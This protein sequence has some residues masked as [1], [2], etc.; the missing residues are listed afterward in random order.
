MSAAHE[1][2]ALSTTNSDEGLSFNPCL[3]NLR[4]VKWRIN[5]GILPSASS[6]IEDLR[7]AAANSRR[8]YA[9][10]RKDLLV[11]PYVAKTRSEADNLAVDNPLSQNPDST[12]GRFFRN[13]ELEKMLD[14]DLSRLYPEHGSYFQTPACQA[15]LRRI[16]LL[17]CLKYQQTHYRQGMHELLAPLL[18]VLHVDVQH[19]V[20]LRKLHRNHFNDRFDCVSF[21]EN[22]LGVDKKFLHGSSYLLTNRALQNGASDGLS[23]SSEKVSSLDEIDPDVRTV[24]LACDAYGAEGELGILLSERFMEHDAYCM[25]DALMTG[26]GG[27]V[28]MADFFSTS[29][30]IGSLM[31]LPP[32]LEA[33]LSLYHLLSFVD[34]SLYFHLVDLGVEP[35]Y[36]ALRWLRVLFGREFLLK[37]LLIIWDAVFELP[38]EPLDCNEEDDFQFGIARS[39]S[40]KFISAFAVSMLLQLRSSLLGTENATS[41]LQRLLNFPP[42]VDVKGLVEK[43][44]SLQVLA[45]DTSISLPNSP[46]FYRSRSSNGRA[47]S[48]SSP[49]RVSGSLSPG[50]LVGLIPESYW[51][52]KWKTS[53]LQR[54]GVQRCNTSNLSPEDRLGKKQTAEPFANNLNNGKEDPREPIK[55]RSLGLEE[56]DPRGVSGTGGSGPD[57]DEKKGREGRIKENNKEFACIVVDECLSGLPVSEDKFPIFS[58]STASLGQDVENE[59]SS[60]KSST[61][62]VLSDEIGDPDPSAV[63]ESRAS[64]SPQQPPDF[65][66]T[67]ATGKDGVSKADVLATSNL[68]TE[69]QPPFKDRK[70]FT[71]FQWFWKFGRNSDEGKTVKGD[72]AETK[73]TKAQ[74]VHHSGS[75]SAERCPACSLPRSGTD[76]TEK[77]LRAT[78]RNLGHSMTENIQVIES[79]LQPERSHVGPVNMPKNSLGVKGQ[80]TAIAALKELKKI[81]NLLS[82]M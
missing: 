49:L 17:W 12:W 28:A 73:K 5:L 41:C 45:F 31:G 43:A 58:T 78:L 61:D 50:T 10:L 30:A 1:E 54:S 67:K 19:L 40:G 2:A 26:A 72:D 74:V 80:V 81:S 76:D 64:T 82:E 3:S 18:Y 27:M 9:D 6:P 22:F 21:T 52:R 14:Q 57:L 39:Y 47:H 32:V 51:E 70:L 34:S 23:G 16:L 71:K 13:A 55:R 60:E 48:L 63:Q 20:Q 35:Q 8:R 36:F 11:D 79:A 15:M 59:N 56:S 68:V 38:K 4:G 75:V 62:A 29:P 33:S 37:D 25:F 69:K 46:S 42:N 65:N 7:R 77:N 53:V 44:R 66:F 24:I